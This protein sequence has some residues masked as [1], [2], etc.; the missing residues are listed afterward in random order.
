MSA[1]TGGMGGGDNDEYGTST[2]VKLRSAIKVLKDEIDLINIQS[3]VLSSV[4]L[5]RS[6]S[7]AKEGLRNLRKKQNS[8]PNSK[9]R[10]KNTNY[11]DISIE[12]DYDDNDVYS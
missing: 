9:F 2:V 12:P 3:G 11:P 5:T 10:N 8:R 4:L 6:A 1:R 7:A